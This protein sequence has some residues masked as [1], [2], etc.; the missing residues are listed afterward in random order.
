MWALIAEALVLGDPLVNHPYLGQCYIACRPEVPV[1]HDGRVIDS[2][3][4]RIVH[5]VLRFRQT[6]VQ[7]RRKQ[8]GAVP[9]CIGQNHLL[10]CSCIGECR[11]GARCT[12]NTWNKHLARSID[13]QTHTNYTSFLQV[14]L[15]WTL[16]LLA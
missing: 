4:G 9:V 14:V 11:V 2:P 1:N 16:T 5:Q 13:L 6:K 8:P 15:T 7:Y 10:R 3:K 12:W